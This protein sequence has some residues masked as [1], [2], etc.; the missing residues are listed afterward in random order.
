MSKPW[1]ILFFAAL[2]LAPVL[3]R[4]SGLEKKIWNVDE[5]VT[6][7]M[8]EQ[9]LAGDVPYRDA[10]DQRNPLAPY[11]QA[12]VFKVTGDW[13]LRAQHFVLA[14][15]IGLTAVLVWRTARRLGEE[16]TGVAGALWV[17]LLCLV[18][19]TVRDTMP[20]HTAWYL[21]FFSCAGF[22]A[23]AHAW[24]SGRVRWAGAAG[25]AFGLSFLA[26]QPGLLDF[27]V[28]LVL[29]A[30]GYGASPERRPRLL[31]QLAG[32]LAGFATPLL[33][34]FAYFAAK[35][36]WA[37]VAYY[38]WT[39]NNVL[40]VPEVAPLERW[41]TMRIPVLL[42]WEYHPALVVMGG[43]AAIGLLVRAP[44]RLLRRPREFD[45]AG[46]MIL[47][48]S[49]SGL[50]A[51][52]LSGRGFSHYSIQLIPGLGL[53]CG[54]ITAR[55]WSAGRKWAG[56]SWFRL[57]LVG[58]V[59]AAGVAWVL[60]PLPRRIQAF[61]L[62]EPGSDVMAQ[63]VRQQT[64]PKDRI[65][66]WGYNPEIYAISQRL[67]ATRFLYNT[68]VTGLIPW[69]NLDA[70]KNT[71]YAVVPGAREALLADWQAHPP[72]VVVDGRSQRGFM[73]YPLEKQPWLWPRLEQDYAEVATDQSALYGFWL[74]R[75]LEPARPEPLPAGLPVAA[76]VQL[77]LP[78]FHVGETA[79]VAVQAPAGTQALELYLDG[80]LYR[81]LACPAEAP[82]DIIF[83]VPV[84]D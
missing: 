57:G 42:A 33:L 8:A 50:I 83:S 62:P 25:G 44:A 65:Y 66:V 11:L 34:T 46:W 27:G 51:S 84:S 14:L 19:P 82:A 78:V 47:G 71:D 41:K 55:L 7:T 37:D 20:A 6:F 53:A 69:T 15:M 48:W 56:P 23:L 54:W 81:R 70:L 63:L 58:A 64:G 79:R 18:L 72:A 5:A 39:Y 12:I 74:F 32:L 29:V 2:V 68:F 60:W 24:H 1:R 52:T 31:R 35:G 67:P 3:L 75:R 17:T 80:V 21:I 45:L 59:A 30:I 76:D 73:K 43:L 22:W 49:A 77:R 61:N 4:W 13:N 16:A 36:A 10:V 26:K 28:A 38:A 40:Y 9:I